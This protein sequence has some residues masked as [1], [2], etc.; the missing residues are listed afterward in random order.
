ML[1]VSSRVVRVRVRVRVRVTV[2]VRV[3]SSRVAKQHHCLLI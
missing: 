2:T 3:I 1:C